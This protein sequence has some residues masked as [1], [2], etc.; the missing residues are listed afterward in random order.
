M[1]NTMISTKK[2]VDPL[3]GV[4]VAAPES[5]VQAPT[6]LAQPPAPKQSAAP[7][8]PEVAP[9]VAQVRPVEQERYRVKETKLISWGGQM[10]RVHGGSI[11]SDE[12]Y[13]PRSFERMRGA[14]V[15]LELAE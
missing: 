5:P 9:V 3:A 6:M 4:R 2:A 10:I 8:A 13:G 15:V 1:S 11:V 7:S 12:K 14:G